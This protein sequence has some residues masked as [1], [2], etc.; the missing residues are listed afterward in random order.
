[1]QISI[2]KNKFKSFG[3]KEEQA[4]QS[5]GLNALLSMDEQEVERTVSQTL[6]SNAAAMIQAAAVNENRSLGL[7]DLFD[8]D[9][10]AIRELSP[11]N[12]FTRLKAY[13]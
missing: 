4:K 1:M 3:K 9:E 5:V 2:L 13:K 12:T 10:S 11:N 6:A 7:N 8:M